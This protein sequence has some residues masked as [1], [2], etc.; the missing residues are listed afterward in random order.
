MKNQAV[1]LVAVAILLAAISF[2]SCKHST[3]QKEKKRFRL[4]AA[5]KQ[6]SNWYW[7]KAYPDP[8]NLSGKYQAAWEQ[9]QELKK[10][11]PLKNNLALRTTSAAN[12]TAIGPKVFGGRMLSIAINRLTATSGNNTIFAGSA[13]GGIWRSYTNG[14]GAT[15]WH[16]VATG[17]PVLGVASIVYHPTDTSTLFA[18]TGEVYRYQTLTNGANSTGQVGNIGRNVWKAR[19]TYGIGILKT[20]N[21]G[22]TWTNV[23]PK[24]SSDLFAVQRIRFDPTNSNTIFACA[25]D[26]LYRS[27]DGGNNW[28]RIWTQ[29][30]VSDVVINPLNNQQ[31]IVAAG[32]VDNTNKGLWRSTNGGTS[33]TKITTTVPTSY[34][35]FKG[36]I[37][38]AST[39]IST[40]TTVFAA[41]G[42]GDTNGDG[43]FTENEVFRSTDFG[44]NWTVISNS[45]HAA[46]QAWFA[47]CMAIYPGV[48]NKLFIAGV[49]RY[50]LTYTGTTTLTG[51]RTGVGNAGAT[52]NSYLT[53]G[54]QEGSTSY[55]HDDVHD[56]QFVPGS[57]TTAYFA[58]DGGIFRT[59][60]ANAATITNITFSTCNGGLQVQQFYPTVGQSQTN[61]NLII[62]GLQDN[63]VIRFNGT[64]WARI[65]GGDGGPVMFKPG[66]ETLV[67]GSRD[68][69]AVYQST[70]SGASFGGAIL[71][72]LGTVPVGNDDRTSF[73]SPIAVSPANPNRWYV[74]SDNL[75]VSTLTGT[76]FSTFTNN[77]ASGIP[78]TN[79]IEARNKTALAMGISSTNANKLY[80]SVSPFAQN[81]TTST[82]A[83][84]YNPPANIRKTTDGGSLFTT[85]TGTLP[86]RL[87]TD[88][89][90]SPTNDDSVFVTLG[91]FGTTH[92]YVTGDGGTTWTPRGSGLP[93]VP[94]N[95]I[96]IDPQN[97]QIL[98]AGCDFGVY[99]SPDRGANWY[100]YND[101]LWDATYVIDLVTAPGNKIRAFTHGKGIFETDRWDGFVVTLPVTLNS[102]KGEN[103]GSYNELSWKVEQEISMD[104]YE[105]QRSTDGLNFSAVA[106]IASRNN[107]QPSSYSYKDNIAQLSSLQFF[108]RL[109]MINQDGSFKYSD[110]VLLKLR[111]SFQVKVLGNPF[112]SEVN[113]R[114]QVQQTGNLQLAVYDQQGKLMKRETVLARSGEGVHTIPGLAYL[115]AG[116]YLLQV[117]SGPEKTTLQ[118]MKQ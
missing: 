104:R 38:L 49:D 69:R 32:N 84:Y 98:Y 118:I 74:G 44:A 103:K 78:L 63:N 95:T 6:L 20:T 39:T 26:G 13:S 110:I 12:W 14:V 65:I 42:N 117:Q 11:S 100:D 85:A 33:F 83:V 86:D 37:T 64:G 36:Y 22:A 31:I 24:L 55:V 67:L 106:T 111:K 96:L 29:D 92:I 58:T 5:D 56:I 51:T 101:G 94:F 71:A 76:T 109:K 25:T 107:W 90:V 79:Y 59:T 112:R 2:S 48:N 34:A 80:I 57:T 114:Y 1:R 8:S 113:L 97:P 108:Y 30:Y 62:G 54:A 88:I 105:L 43:S 19:G 35:T 21:A 47:H 4:S 17:F 52:M 81:V 16:P 45:N 68:T 50:V 77:N 18:G 9:Y 87:Y 116:M 27:T 46:F 89:A 7:Q 73:M 10:N 70:N 53:P 75:H 102:F 3:E 41:F 23:L 66:D 115:P 72:Y 82:E 60:N 91:G 99:V 93:D 61:A 15:A 40:T 28:T